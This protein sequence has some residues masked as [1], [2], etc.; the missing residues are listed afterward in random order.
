MRTI[1]VVGKKFNL[2]RGKHGIPD[3]NIDQD[4]LFLSYEKDDDQLEIFESIDEAKQ[5]IKSPASVGIGFPH[6]SFVTPIFSVTLPKNQIDAISDSK[7]K[8]DDIRNKITHVE[9]EQPYESLTDF[10]EA[11]K[12]IASIAFFEERLALLNIPKY[13]NGGL[14]VR[15]QLDR[16]TTNVWPDLKPEE[17]YPMLSEIFDELYPNNGQISKNDA[18][19]FY[20]VASRII[21]LQSDIMYQRN[22]TLSIWLTV[23]CCLPIITIP[24]SLFIYNGLFRL[25]S[26]NDCI[27]NQEVS[28]SSVGCL[29]KIMRKASD[30]QFNK[31]DLFN[32]HGELRKIKIAGDMNGTS[33]VEFRGTKNQMHKL[34]TKVQKPQQTTTSEDKYRVSYRML[35]GV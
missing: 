22:N 25:F 32:K 2:N 35:H 11:K 9:F 23:L 33:S 5:A 21:N 3:N 24:F 15:Q 18:I 16:A 4:R 29:T 13:K 27:Q 12:L 1:Y 6:A 30:A 34:F 10:P 31:N 8:F 17:I 26:Q 7:I 20:H 28:T 14:F 19:N